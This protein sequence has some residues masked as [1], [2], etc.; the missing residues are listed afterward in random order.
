[1]DEEWKH[2]TESNYSVRSEGRVKNNNTGKLLTP[3]LVGKKGNQ[4]Y[5]VDLRP[6]KSVKIH[7]LVAYYFIG[8]STL[9]VNH[10]NGNKTDNSVGNLEYCTAKE[11]INHAWNSGLA[12]PQRGN[13]NGVSKIS[14]DLAYKIKY[15]LP[16]KSHKEWA[17]ALGVSQ[18]AVNLIR[19]GRN[20]AWL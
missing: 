17:D 18:N 10:K 7:R 1:M 2:I 8:A 9:Q 20:W 6:K 19:K 12:K 5:A 3:F 16:E 4:Y 14:K 13:D 15:T 11:N